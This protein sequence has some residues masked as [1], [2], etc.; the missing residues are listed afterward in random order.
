MHLLFL[1]NTKERISQCA[2]WTCVCRFV[3]FADGD[4]TELTKF[5]EGYGYHSAFI[6]M[7]DPSGKLLGESLDWVLKH[8]L[9]S[10]NGKNGVNQQGSYWQAMINLWR[11]DCW[12]HNQLMLKC[13]LDNFSHYFGWQLK[14]F[15]DG[16]EHTNDQQGQR[17]SKSVLWDY[18]E[19]YVTIKHT[20]CGSADCSRR[21]WYP[22]KDEIINLQRRVW[23]LEANA[24]RAKATDDFD[25]TV[26]FRV[27]AFDE[28]PLGYP[29]K[30][31]SQNFTTPRMLLEP[32]SNPADSSH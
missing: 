25:V 23:T 24:F 13:G 1:G 19:G 18:D 11:K 17:N 7:Y 22:L 21:F 3:T 31:R 14:A 26:P 16:V 27:T 32:T 4:K 29:D 30:P 10:L 9:A 6:R 8:D 20:V 2:E 28:L 12:S 5:D 15:P